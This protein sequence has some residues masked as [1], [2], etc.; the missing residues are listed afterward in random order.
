MMSENRQVETKRGA[1]RRFLWVLRTTIV[2]LLIV[3]ILAGIVWLAYTGSEELKRS[4]DS[5]AE[6]IEANKQRIALLNDDIAKLKADDPLGEISRLR[7]ETGDL[8]TRLSAIQEQLST[9]MINQADMLTALQ[10]EVAAVTSSSESTAAGT[11]AVSEALALLQADINDSNQRIDELGG[12]LDT[13]QG[14]TDQLDTNF[15]QFTET[16]VSGTELD[17]LQ[18]TLALFHTWE[19]IA[20]ARLY[21]AEN[22]VGL[23][24]DDVEQA[25]RLLDLLIAT[26]GEDEAEALAIVQ[27][28]LS[29][30][31]NSLPTDLGTAVRDLE[32]AWNQ[33]DDILTARL[34]PAELL[35]APLAEAAEA[36]TEAGAETTATPEATPETTPEATPEATPTS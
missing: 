26:S 21:L 29:L 27:T 7:G 34:F 13:L 15:G 30:A 12:E 19:R 16:A 11:S 2:S 33:L 23:A 18:Q 1:G 17:D 22:N 32:N 36:E 25:Q 20:R 10:E 9:D 28:R 24:I 4:F 14:Q 31:F 8:E 3:V 35:E 5:V 6:R